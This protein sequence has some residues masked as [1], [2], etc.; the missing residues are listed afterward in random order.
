MDAFLKTGKLGK[1]DISNKSG[2]SGDAQPG[3][4]SKKRSWPVPWVEK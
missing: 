1:S 3:T 2:D 4:S